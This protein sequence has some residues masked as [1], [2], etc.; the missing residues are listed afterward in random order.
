MRIQIILLAAIA[1]SIAA[2]CVFGAEVRYSDRGTTAKLHGWDV[3]VGKA[4][5]CSDPI[6]RVDLQAFICGI[7]GRI[8]TDTTVRIDGESRILA[9]W[10][11]LGGSV[12]ICSHPLADMT[13]RTISCVYLNQLPPE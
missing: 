10:R 5:A 9:G 11:V 6:V 7:Q 8:E 12:D 4:K 1:V 2:V 3:M 13:Y